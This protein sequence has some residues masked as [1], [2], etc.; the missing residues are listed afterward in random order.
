MLFRKSAAKAMLTSTGL[1]AMLVGLSTPG[2]ADLTFYTDPGAYQSA[3]SNLGRQDETVDFNDPGLLDNGPTITG[4]ATSI[5][6][7]IREVRFEEE[8]GGG[9]DINS[10]SGGQARVE[11]NDGGLN[12][13]YITTHN[14]LDNFTA[15]TANPN[16]F[17]QTTGFARVTAYSDDGQW[18]YTLG[19]GQNFFGIV[20]TNNQ[21]F[22]AVF[23]EFF[24]D[25]TMT[26]PLDIQDVRQVRVEI[27]AVPEPAFYQLAGLLGLGGIG[28][29]RFRKKKAA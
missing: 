6:G 8:A 26:T 1:A 19:S 20:A 25:S 2:R 16:L 27:N 17:T 18:T 11:A 13:L 14:P 22:D 7:S 12:S 15:L 21:S 3:L 24:T 10:P 9:E 28:L 23:L 5:Q 4:E 29:L